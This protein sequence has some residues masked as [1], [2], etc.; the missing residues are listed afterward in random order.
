ME[1]FTLTAGELT[2]DLPTEADI[3]LIT[4]YCQ[5]PLFEKFLTIP[6]PYSQADAEFFV[7]E[8]VQPGWR[9][10]DELT[11]AIRL[12]GQL[13]GVISVRAGSSMIGYWMGAE[14][15]GSGHMSRA[16][17]AVID[18]VFDSGWS[19]IVTWEARIGNIGSLAV[20]RAMGLRYTGIGP[21]FTA[22]R[23]GSTPDCW[24]AELHASDERTR[25]DG[26]PDLTEFGG[27]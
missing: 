18:W 5:D 17:A 3:P 14:H 2:L 22:S 23:D 27:R 26:W 12:D 15:R 21:A 10:G 4:E 25:K 13:L 20:A 16:V 1:P 9:S 24:R 8:I 7:H 19:E 6:W 11:W